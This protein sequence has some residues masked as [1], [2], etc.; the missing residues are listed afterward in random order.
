MGMKGNTQPVIP[1][2]TETYSDSTDAPDEAILCTIKIF[3]YD[4]TYY[5]LG[6][7]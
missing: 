1:F 2:V 6:K 5:S 4:S 7:R 3:K